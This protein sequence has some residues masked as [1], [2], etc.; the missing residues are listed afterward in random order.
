MRIARIQTTHGIRHAVANGDIWAVI[1]DPFADEIRYTG[2]LVPLIGAV[3]LAPVEPKIVI[4]ITHNLT[5]ND[6][7]LP[8]QAWHKSVRTVAGPG[9]TF[10]LAH[11]VGTV[12]IEGELAVVIGKSASN[13]T[14][15]TAF[16]AVRGYTI[17]NDVTNVDQVAID[18][19]NFQSKAGHNYTPLGPWIETEIAN[20]EDVAIEVVVNGKVL[21]RSGSFNLPST[22]AQSL[23]YV[24]SWLTLGPGD[25]IM[26]G[27]PKTFFAVRPGDRVDITIA[28]IGTL[29]NFVV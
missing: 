2:E 12:N 7:P 18:E 13:L 5:I 21:V 4:G 17:A 22:V 14:L 24:T 11:G 16:E 23:V 3:L 9:D 26:T 6:H 15:E 10:R 19:K 25:I 20:P 8:I 28:G 27:A 29:S 1:E